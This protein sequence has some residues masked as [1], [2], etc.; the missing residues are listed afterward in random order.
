MA[1]FNKDWETEVI[2]DASP[3]GLGAVLGQ[4]NPK[5]PEEK[6]IVCFASRML[7]DVESGIANARRK[8]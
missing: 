6:H 8:L 2:V 4:F 1:Y 5:N 3:V 7:T